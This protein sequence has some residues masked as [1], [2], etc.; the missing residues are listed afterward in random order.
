MENRPLPRR[1]RHEEGRARLLEAALR[2]LSRKGFEGT[3]V[4]DVCRAAG[5]SKGGF[6]FYFRGKDDVLL[7]LVEGLVD[8]SEDASPLAEGWS[9][10]LL[11]ELWGHA[12]RKPLIRER[13]A[14]YYATR[15]ERLSQAAGE[16]RGSAA[17]PEVIADL[18]LA[19]ET[20]LQIQ[21][22]LLAGDSSHDRAQRALGALLSASAA[23]GDLAGR[24]STN[25]PSK[26][27]L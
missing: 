19:L 27:K 12:C 6:Y 16:I 9:G 17:A 23:G 2:V 8:G 21:S 10:G 26:S 25:I 24:R 22:Q 11:T 18:I 14:E 7:Q 13:L 5:Y 4:E 20:G 1:Q 15:R 3:S